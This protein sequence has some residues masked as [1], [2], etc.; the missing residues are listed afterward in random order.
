ME[1]PMRLRSAVTASWL[2]LAA[3]PCV[4]NNAQDAARWKC[5]VAS[6]SITPEKPIHLVGYA[7]RATPFESVADDIYAKALAIDDAE[8]N[9]GVIVS[10]DLVGLQDAF[11]GTVCQRLRERTGLERQQ[12]LLNASHNHTG[13]L[14]SLSPHTEGN[15]AHGAMTPEQAEETVRYSR[16]LQDKL[17]QLVEDA[18]ADLQPAELAW[19]V[20]KVS[21]V[22]NRRNGSAGAIQ[23]APNPNGPIDPTIPVLRVTTPDGKLRCVLFG[24]A[25]HNTTIATNTN[26]I[27]GD[28][29]GYAQQQLQS[30]HPGVQ[31]MFLSGCG[32]DA[33]PEPRGDLEVARR[34]GAELATAVSKVLAGRLEALSGPLQTA[35]ELVDLPLKQLTANELD[36]YTA[37]GDSQ[38][39][40]SP[41]LAQ[42]LAEGHALRTHYP[43]PIAAWSLGEGLTLVALPGEG[44]AEYAELVG[45]RLNSRKL[46]VSSYNNDCFGYLPTAQIVREGGHEAIGVTAWFWGT[47]LANSAGFFSEEVEE[48][49]LD[50]VERV[51]GELHVADHP[52][53]QE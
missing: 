25:C 24:C 52:L 51:V 38:S 1:N 5:G 7:G 27:S 32:A 8:G 11:S 19:G 9:R 43:A 37:R 23:M 53:R 46:W 39:W 26:V 13:P 33:N 15:L 29:A 31:A 34:H 41:H 10:C 35:Y 50:A 48:T 42:R 4:A 17:V 3:L 30:Q 45:R 28:Y 36:A 2:L 20:G 12:L 14:V 22:M 40:L 16:Q 47:H 6:V 49:V 18:L 21:F 44:V